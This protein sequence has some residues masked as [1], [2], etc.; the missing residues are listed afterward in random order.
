MCTY[1]YIQQLFIRNSIG[2]SDFAIHH[3]AT[4]CFSVAWHC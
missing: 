1:V 2:S 4:E 3:N